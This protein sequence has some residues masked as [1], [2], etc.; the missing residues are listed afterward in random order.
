M[1]IRRLIPNARHHDAIVG[2]LVI[3]LTLFVMQFN[4]FVSALRQL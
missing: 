2:F 3:I 1:A 4:T